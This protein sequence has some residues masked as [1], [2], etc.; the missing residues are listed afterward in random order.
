[1]PSSQEDCLSILDKIEEI[2]HTDDDLSGLPTAVP[3]RILNLHFQDKR[4]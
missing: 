4:I 1:M 2:A 3:R